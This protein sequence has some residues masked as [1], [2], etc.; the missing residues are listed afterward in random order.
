M[1]NIILVE[2]HKPLRESLVDVMAAEGYQVAAF[3]SAEAFRAGS[4]RGSVDI[5]V[6]DLNLPGED[7]ISLARRVR[8]EQPGI[9]I[10]MLTA[11]AEPEQREIGYESGADIYLTKPSSVPELTS[12]IRALAR[13][14]SRKPEQKGLVLDPR[15]MTLTGAAETVA[16]T[17]AEAEILQ[18][19]IRSPNNRVK[20]DRIIAVTGSEGEVSKA[21]IEV[22]IVRLRK[23]MLA[24]GAIGRPINMVRNHGYQLSV[25]VDIA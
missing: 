14:L 24:A 22:R 18:E 4:D 10:V 11:R 16:L 2:D 23:K 6:L 17:A 13:R 21:A 9:G 15:A 19:F 25:Q 7:G 8:V 3:D 20:T 1:L 5:L 12:S